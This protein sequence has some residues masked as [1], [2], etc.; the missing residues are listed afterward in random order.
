[1]PRDQIVDA[2]P[3]ERV[4]WMEM[5]TLKRTWGVSIQALLY[6]ARTLGTLGET[7]YENAMKTMSR[8]GWRRTEPGYL[9]RPERPQMLSKAI[10]ALASVGFTMD[11]LVDLTRL[12]EATLNA[13]LGVE[14]EQVPEFGAELA[15]DVER[16][17]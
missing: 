6:R 16:P 12:S 7:A 5:V 17:D 8:R 2:L 9:G 1:M 15:A 11:D 3:H 13:I 10:E 14:R 4:N